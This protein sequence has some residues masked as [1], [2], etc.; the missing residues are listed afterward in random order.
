LP[1]KDVEVTESR[2]GNGWGGGQNG[3]FG[4]GPSRFDKAETFGSSY[5][6]PGWQRAQTAAKNAGGS[7]GSFNEGAT[8]YN[9]GASRGG[10]RVIEGELIAKSTGGGAGFSTGQRVFHQKFGYGDILATE[11]NKLTVQFD[12]AGEKKVLDSFVQ[13]A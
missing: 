12:K 6:T 3:R 4:Y 7:G 1:E 5:S 13:E 2:G 10:G 9:P 11:G 8:R